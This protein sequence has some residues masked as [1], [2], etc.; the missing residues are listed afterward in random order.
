MIKRVNIVVGLG[1]SIIMILVG[2]PQWAAYLGYLIVQN[3]DFGG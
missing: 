1:V 2:S 3:H